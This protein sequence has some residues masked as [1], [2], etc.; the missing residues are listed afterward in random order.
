MPFG[1]FSERAL[2]HL[3]VGAA[4]EAEAT[5]SGGMLGPAPLRHV[6]AKG[7]LIRNML[8]ARR[9]AFTRGLQSGFADGFPDARAW[10]AINV[11]TGSK[12]AL[13]AVYGSQM[14]GLVQYSAISSSVEYVYLNNVDAAHRLMAILKGA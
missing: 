9:L 8:K 12:R 5:I 6:A 7:E 2:A 11:D 4:F 14:V 1:V 10:L 3:P 13:C